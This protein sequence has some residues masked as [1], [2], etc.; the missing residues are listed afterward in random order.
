MVPR[1]VE[2]VDG[3]LVQLQPTPKALPQDPYDI[4][5]MLEF[6]YCRKS[7][8]RQKQNSVRNATGIPGTSRTFPSNGKAITTSAAA[9]W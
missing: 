7:N 4:A 1:E 8:P 3:G 2:R 9:K 5:L 6:E